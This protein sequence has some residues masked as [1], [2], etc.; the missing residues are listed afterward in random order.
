MPKKSIKLESQSNKIEIKKH[1]SLIQINNKEMSYYSKKI[2][3]GLIYVVKKQLEQ[4]PNRRVFDFTLAEI[5]HITWINQ[6]NHGILKEAL[7]SMKKT[8]IEY[9]LLNKDK[10]KIWWIMSL[11]SELRYTVKWGDNQWGFDWEVGKRGYFSIELP[12]T[13]R[14]SILNPNVFTKLNLFLLK[15]L[16]TKYSINLYE[17]LKDYE[18]KN[19]WGGIITVKVG[20]LKQ[21]IWLEKDKYKD[22]SMFR[23]RVINP[24]L[25]QINKMTDI[26]VSYKPIKDWRKYKN[27]EF[28]ISNVEK[29]ENKT[30]NEKTLAMELKLKNYFMLWIKQIREV[31]LR[32]KDFDFLESRLSQIEVDYKKW[33]IKNIWPYTYKV[34][35]ESSMA[36]RSLFDTEMEQEKEEQKKQAELEQKKKEEKERKRKEEAEKVREEAEDYYLSL[37]KEDQEK[38][39]EEY[40]SSLNDIIKKQYHKYWVES[41]LFKGQFLLFVYDKI[42]K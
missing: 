20:V 14:N 2:F 9:N 41:Q 8:D 34:L 31:L 11:F 37:S 42:N 18:W 4:D 36:E 16:S 10:E 15:W 1:S 23:R 13:I 28:Y 22:F 6:T 19:R 38:M 5:K 39:L 30:E 27:I 40:E 35:T 3:N 29:E 26:E 21:I 12:E 25:E 17:F 7:I 33:N 24:A 32:Y